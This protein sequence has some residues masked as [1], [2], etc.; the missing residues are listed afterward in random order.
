[1]RQAL[2]VGNW[3]MHGS[4]SSVAALLDSLVEGLAANSGSNREA[5]VAI[6]PSYVFLPQALAACDGTALAVGAQDCSAEPCGA[7]TGE[8][9]ASMLAELGCHWV[10]LGHSE[11]RQYHSESDD[12][13]AAKLLAAASAGLTPI[14]C[15][16]E[17]REQREAGQAEQ[18][19]QAQLRGALAKADSTTNSDGALVVAYEPVWAIG[20]GLT[21]TPEEAQAM[22]ALIRTTLSALNT[23]A[24][25][26]I[27]YGGSVK[28]DNAEQLFAQRDIDG[29]LVG[30]A[31][32]TAPE[33]LAVV[34][35]ANERAVND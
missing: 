13:V 9:A 30:G 17:T 20:T 10:I 29:A 32:L 5:A 34:A 23:S 18:V 24:D 33:F 11:R 3:K 7:R 16:G 15:V 6:C 27:L 21:A 2:V 1:M 31:S 22:H 26:R 12:L 8:V 4:P 19:V 25:T 35:A 14:L 28:P